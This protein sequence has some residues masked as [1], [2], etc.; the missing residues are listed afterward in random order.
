MVEPLMRYNS[1]TSNKYK[2]KEIVRVDDV[3]TKN[4]SISNIDNVQWNGIEKLYRV[5]KE[6]V[7]LS[8]NLKSD[9]GPDDF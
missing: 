1:C 2:K 7:R 3:L 4:V 5:N 6:F 9:I 8:D